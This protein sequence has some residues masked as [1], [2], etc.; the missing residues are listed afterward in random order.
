ME[1][2]WKELYSDIVIREYNNENTN[3]YFLLT[4]NYLQVQILFSL[5]DNSLEVLNM[6]FFVTMCFTDNLVVPS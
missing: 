2:D 5:S 4:V 6:I 1:A 3:A